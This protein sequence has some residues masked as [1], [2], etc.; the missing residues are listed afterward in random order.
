MATSP[1]SS[2]EQ[3]GDACSDQRIGYVIAD[4]SRARIVMW[5]SAARDYHTRLTLQDG[6]APRAA[7]VRRASRGAVYESASPQR[8]GLGD[9]AA[10]RERI[11]QAFADVLV[12][13]IH[14]FVTETPVEG[15]VLAAPRAVPEAAESGPGRRP[16]GPRVGRQES[17]Q[18]AGSRARRLADASGPERPAALIDHRRDLIPISWCGRSTVVRS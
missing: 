4:G 10:A 12:E 9:R 3:R 13:Q 6:A 7:R 1:Q 17:G 5:D 8:H 15:L 18:D 14:A 11:R 16:A 2:V